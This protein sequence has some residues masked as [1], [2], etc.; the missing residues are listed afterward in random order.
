MTNYTNLL[1]YYLV[2]LTLLVYFSKK[3]TKFKSNVIYLKRS[4]HELD[5][6]PNK[7]LVTNEEGK[8]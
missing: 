1:S 3:L 7:L 8:V 2:L 4:Q 6:P 5:F